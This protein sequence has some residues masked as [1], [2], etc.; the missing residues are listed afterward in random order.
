MSNKS[1]VSLKRSNDET[2]FFE[3]K[4][5][6]RDIVHDVYYDKNNG[7]VCSCE[8]YYY[9]K[10]FCKHMRLARAYYKSFFDVIDNDTVYA[11]IR[12]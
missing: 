1:I 12:D 7:W 4:S 9:R 8:Q 5:N 6:S 11:E 2:L 3:V 10:K